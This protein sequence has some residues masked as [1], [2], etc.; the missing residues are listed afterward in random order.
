M[1]PEIKVVMI[2]YERRL[3]MINGSKTIRFPCELFGTKAVSATFPPSGHC[4][5]S[6]RLEQKNTL[7]LW[8]PWHIDS[9]LSLHSQ[10]QLEFNQRS[11]V[12]NLRHGSQDQR[13]R[14]LEKLL[15]IRKASI[16]RNTCRRSTLAHSFTGDFLGL[17]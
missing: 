12:E 16:S 6:H 13:I 5:R 17:R 14:G 10:G 4:P 7:P 1:L 11:P 9:A 3:D 2:R 8:Y 15:D